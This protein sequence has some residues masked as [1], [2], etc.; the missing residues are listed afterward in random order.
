MHVYFWVGWAPTRKGGRA[1]KCSIEQLR[2]TLEA[3]EHNSIQAR[4][5]AMVGHPERRRVILL[6]VD[7]RPTSDKVL[8]WA[9]ENMYRV[10]EKLLSFLH[11][12][13]DVLQLPLPGLGSWT[14]ARGRKGHGRLG[15]LHATSL[16]SCTG[17]V[18]TGPARQA[19][20][21]KPGCPDNHAA[22]DGTAALL[23]A[24]ALPCCCSP[25]TSSTSCTSSRPLSRLQPPTSPLM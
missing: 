11:V 10:S 12:V 5:I 19:H 7:E 15:Q 18:T 21:A 22:S 16:S 17:C 2:H 24:C 25:G 3:T 8:D 23:A 1:G 20:H 4:Q 13:D 9:V 6:T 14:T